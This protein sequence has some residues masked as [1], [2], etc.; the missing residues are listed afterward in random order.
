M[1]SL[2]Q[3]PDKDQGSAANAE[4]RQL[5][6]KVA[7]NFHEDVYFSAER[8]SRQW[9]LVALFGMAM[10]AVGLT[11]VFFLLPLKTFVP[12]YF[13]EDPV[14][15]QHKA[16]PLTKQPVT[17]TVDTVKRNYWINQFVSARESWNPILHDDRIKLLSV[18][19]SK[20]VIGQYVEEQQRSSDLNFSDRFGEHTVRNISATNFSHLNENTTAFRFI[21][22]DRSEKGTV[23]YHWEGVIEYYWNPN[24]EM[25]EKARLLNPY[26]F[27][28]KRYERKL[29]IIDN[30]G[31]AQ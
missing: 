27:T 4:R 1:T 11:L 29:E 12:V 13:V 23:K 28:V 9:R 6:Y 7:R 31:K 20:R 21:T 8:R 18:L 24:M 16:M 15:G 22:E 2:S 26:G 14:T 25:A 17:F 3:K 19:S 10:G 30:K 5:Y